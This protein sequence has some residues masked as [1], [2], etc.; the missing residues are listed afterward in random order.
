MSTELEFILWVCDHS[1]RCIIDICKDGGLTEEQKK[2]RAEGVLAL[3]R[4]LLEQDE[5]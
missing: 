4:A 3:Q 1:S 2:Q 5:D